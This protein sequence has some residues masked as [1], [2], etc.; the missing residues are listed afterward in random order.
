MTVAKIEIED[1]NYVVYYRGEKVSTQHTIMKA[2]FK[3]YKFIKG[4]S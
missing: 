4:R 3:L 2:A 1:G